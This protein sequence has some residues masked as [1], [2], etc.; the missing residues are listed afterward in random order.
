MWTNIVLEQR[1]IEV[2]F[3]IDLSLFMSTFWVFKPFYSWSSTLCSTDIIGYLQTTLSYLKLR[4]KM[5]VQSWNKQNWQKC[6]NIE[7]KP[8]GKT[9][10]VRWA[11]VRQLPGFVAV[12][13]EPVSPRQSNNVTKQ[14]EIWKNFVV[15]FS[16]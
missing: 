8:D 1:V 14:Y 5:F 7:K 9:P 10:T 13:I 6:K 12:P 11:F 2:G 4:I 3:T 16:C 15:S